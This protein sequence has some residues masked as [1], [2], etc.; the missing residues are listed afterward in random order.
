[1]MFL[2]VRLY[3]V[4]LGVALIFGAG[5]MA[6]GW[7][8]AGKFEAERAEHAEQARQQTLQVLAAQQRLDDAAEER[9]RSIEKAVAPLHTQIRAIDDENLRMS[10]CIADRTCGVR[11]RT[12]VSCPAAAVP[13][14]PAS[15]G[16]SPAAGALLPSDAGQVVFDLRANIERTERTL[17]ACQAAGSAINVR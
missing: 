8:W 3:L 9:Q 16:G 2:G 12:V 17:A 15:A 5:W 1:M 6:N 13:G 4:A 7:R 10:R 14:A 11:L